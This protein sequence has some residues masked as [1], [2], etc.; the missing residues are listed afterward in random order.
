MK[1]KFD[2]IVKGSNKR[3]NSADLSQESQ[4]NKSNRASSLSSSLAFRPNLSFSNMPSRIGSTR[5]FGIMDGRSVPIS[6]EK[7]PSN[8]PFN[9]PDI[10]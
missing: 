6:R 7:S 2:E 4:H 1:K 9:S 10:S 5:N 3:I 8:L